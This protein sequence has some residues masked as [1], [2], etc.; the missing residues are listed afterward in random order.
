MPIEPVLSAAWAWVGAASDWAAGAGVPP[1]Q[2]LRINAIDRTSTP[3]IR[4][5]RFIVSLLGVWWVCTPWS[6]VR[7]YVHLQ[8]IA[9]L[10]CI[11]CAGIDGIYGI[12][13][14]THSPSDRFTLEGIGGPDRKL[15]SFPVSITI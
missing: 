13:F 10:K 11:C 1:P 9:W 12:L 14:H 6:L 5:E 15:L 3:K 7:A 4:L 2:A 8:R